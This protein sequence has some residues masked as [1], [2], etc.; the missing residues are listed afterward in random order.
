MLDTVA[1]PPPAMAPPPVG[2]EEKEGLEVEVGVAPPLLLR[3]ALYAKEGV[4][5]LIGGVGV[6]LGD[7]P[8]PAGEEVERRNGEEEGLTV[9]AEAGGGEA[10]GEI[11]EVGVGVGAKGVLV[12]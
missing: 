2:L 12:E 7:A 1:P 3:V 5:A 6:S 10:V 9:P 4:A 11:V 8:V